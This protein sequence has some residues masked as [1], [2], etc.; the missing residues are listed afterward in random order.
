MCGRAPRDP[1]EKRVCTYYLE[2]WQLVR[3]P[4]QV[5]R[6]RLV[7]PLPGLAWGRLETALVLRPPRG[8]CRP[9]S[10]CRSSSETCLQT[11]F[12]SLALGRSKLWT[13]SKLWTV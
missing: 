7:C 8:P 12:R 4:V 10:L 13:G 9:C 11:F 6:Q 2:L 5:T 1:W 3:V